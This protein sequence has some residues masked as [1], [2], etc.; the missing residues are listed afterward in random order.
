[1]TLKHIKEAAS[2]KTKQ[3]SNCSEF[4]PHAIVYVKVVVILTLICQV[5]VV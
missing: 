5:Y 1:M 4:M 2:G 3:R